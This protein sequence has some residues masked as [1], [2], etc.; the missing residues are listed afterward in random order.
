MQRLPPEQYLIG[1]ERDQ[2][3]C[4]CACELD[5]DRFELLVGG[6]E[7]PIRGAAVR[8][9]PVAADPAAAGHGDH[10]IVLQR[11]RC[12]GA[13]GGGLRR[14][15][16]I[17]KCC[18]RPT[19][20]AGIEAGC[21]GRQ[22]GVIGIDVSRCPVLADRPWN[23]AV[24]ALPRQGQAKHR[25]GGEGIVRADLR[26][27]PR[28][29]R[30][31]HGVGERLVIDSQLIKPPAGIVGQQERLIAEV[32]GGIGCA[33]AAV[34]GHHLAIHQQAGGALQGGQR[35][36][37]A[38]DSGLLVLRQIGGGDVVPLPI[39]Q[40]HTRAARERQPRGHIEHQLPQAIHRNRRS[41]QQR[42]IELVAAVL[43]VAGSR[44]G[45]GGVAAARGQVEAHLG[46][47][48]LLLIGPQ[49]VE[50]G[51]EVDVGLHITRL[52]QPPVHRGRV[53]VHGDAIEIG[54]GKIAVA[55]IQEGVELQLREWNAGQG[56][57]RA[58]IEA[59]Q[60]AGADAIVVQE[61]VD[62]FQSHAADQIVD[63][64][65]IAVEVAAA[66]AAHRRG[67]S[68]RG[69]HG[70][71]PA[72]ERRGIGA[73]R[74]RL[75]QA[76]ADGLLIG[77][78]IHHEAGPQQPALRQLGRTDRACRRLAQRHQA[79]AVGIGVRLQ[80]SPELEGVGSAGSRRHGHQGRVDQALA[81]IDAVAP[82][83]R[84]GFKG[85][86]HRRDPGAGLNSL[87]CQ[88][89]AHLQAALGQ[90]R[91]RECGGLDRAAETQ[92]PGR[93]RQRLQGCD[94]HTLALVDRVG[95]QTGNGIDADQPRDGGAG[96]HA[97]T[98]EAITQ[99]RPARRQARH[100]EGSAADAAA[101]H[102]HGGGDAAG[103]LQPRPVEAAQAGAEH[104]GAIDVLHR[105]RLGF[106]QSSGQGKVQ[107]GGGG[108]RGRGAGLL[109]RAEIDAVQA[110]LQGPE[111]EIDAGFIVEHALAV[112]RA[113]PLAPA[114]Q[115]RLGQAAIC[116]QQGLGGDADVLDREPHIGTGIPGNR[117]D[118][119]LTVGIAEQIVPLQGASIGIDEAR[120]DHGR[121]CCSRAHIRD[122]S[123]NRIDRQFAPDQQGAAATRGCGIGHVERLQLGDHRPLGRVEIRQSRSLPFIT[124][125]EAVVDT[126]LAVQGLHVGLIVRRPIAAGDRHHRI[127][128][129]HPG[130]EGVVAVRGGCG[131]GDRGGR[132]PTGRREDQRGV[133]VKLL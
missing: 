89:I 113:H 3:R 129:L 104:T 25:D 126:L 66:I 32:L 72:I 35:H 78:P 87:A 33:Y 98:A 68:A 92:Q 56:G 94:R 69:H 84:G 116:Q 91:H 50:Q 80:L 79:R 2:G 107:T 95:A 125:L 11:S 64:Q 73:A 133:V 99:L 38:I 90:G 58:A 46:F 15:L 23:R 97:R 53:G 48:G 117:L 27:H 101:E 4:R 123:L 24:A 16:W 43:L 39:A 57:G 67:V 96:Q 9:V 112:G 131:S 110:C 103:Q 59:N 109:D 49:S 41:V 75:D 83:A 118:D 42:E 102:R 60:L 119:R 36:G 30:R 121:D 52:Q 18:R 6:I 51:V 128:G 5:G 7:K 111:F 88:S 70:P 122:R 105:R 14:Q 26:P 8:F 114:D 85:R 86:Q 34:A 108:Q 55:A 45:G 12:N 71:S 62:P 81:A 28:H 22:Q 20:A 31:R 37:L 40:I 17:Q 130:H 10:Q 54:G 106:G 44:W 47:A 63:L 127:G 19:V 13:W 65:R 124:R 61:L 29:P 21:I 120:L 74:N 100:A 1:V 82:L 76:R 115:R 77:D 93:L 132:G